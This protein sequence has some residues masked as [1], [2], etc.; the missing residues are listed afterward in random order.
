MYSHCISIS[1]PDESIPAEAVDT[2][3]E[4]LSLRFHDI[5]SR[6]DLPQA[7]RARPPRMRHVRRIVRFYRRTRA[8]A[9]G[10][11]IHCHAGVHRSTAVALFILYLETGSEQRAAEEL[12]RL[13]PLPMPNT[14]LVRL[15]DRH[16]GSQLEQ[17]NT[18]LW[19]RAR[20]FAAGRVNIDPDDYLEELE[21]ED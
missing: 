13:K 5:T 20:D 15:F 3:A 8:Q 1:D 21:A 19:T 16:A 11:T 17:Y 7:I 12:L 4:V 14:R 2:F 10:Y 6:R 18:A 9:S